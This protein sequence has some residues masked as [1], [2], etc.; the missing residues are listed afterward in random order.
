MTEHSGSGGNYDGFLIP[1]T[2]Y[3]DTL[4]NRSVDI[5][6]K[7]QTLT[8]HQE[9]SG[10]D[11]GEGVITKS[12]QVMKWSVTGK[13]GDEKG[14]PGKRNNVMKHLLSECESPDSAGSG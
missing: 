11:P 4:L 8:S 6:L 3:P 5:Q 1:V 13:W 2:C 10:R 14:I 12:C 7:I 9:E